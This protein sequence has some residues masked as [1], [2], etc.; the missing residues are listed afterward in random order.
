MKF[1]KYNLLVPSDNAGHYYLFNT[2]NGCCLDV[3]DSIADAVRADKVDALD[4]ETTDLFK[5]TGVLLP[6]HIDENKVFSYMYGVEKF[7]PQTLSSTVLL[8]GGV[9][10]D[11][12]IVF[13]ATRVVSSQ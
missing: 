13:K 4:E 6:S 3:E 9:T 12:L 8:T 10:L 11:A 5:R 1:S 7:N 2:F